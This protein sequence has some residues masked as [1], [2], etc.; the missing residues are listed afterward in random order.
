MRQ[1]MW[2]R[3]N[4]RERGANLIEAALVL[5]LLL[6]LLAGVVDLGR[7]FY[8]YV[9]LTNAV[10]EG[11]RFASR[12]PYEGNEGVI[13]DLVV[14]RV[15]EEPGFS[16]IPTD[17]IVVDDPIEG[18]GG[19]KGTEVTVRAS[20]L[21]DTILGGVLGMESFTIRTEATMRIFGVDALP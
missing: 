14:A 15:K 11:A 10:R 13:A 2:V 18:L 17:R 4:E 6:L 8:S 5:P 7:A 12:F 16:D 9:T 20:L 1:M 21:Y 19:E 3:S